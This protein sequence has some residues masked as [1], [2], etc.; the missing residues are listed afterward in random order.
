[1]S[2]KSQIPRRPL[3]LVVCQFHGRMA[4]RQVCP[5]C[6]DVLIAEHRQMVG[7]IKDYPGVIKQLIDA[8]DAA[9][10]RAKKLEAGVAEIL[11]ATH[12][13]YCTGEVVN[14]D[15]HHPA[16]RFVQDLLYG[17]QAVDPVAGQIT[18]APEQMEMEPA[19]LLP[20]IGAIMLGGRND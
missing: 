5:K 18:P 2:A 16:C 10:A 19:E 8:G 9:N 11:D 6:A 14:D 3:N 20:G 15:Y 7:Q 13:Q 1:M 12:T 4:P 17:R